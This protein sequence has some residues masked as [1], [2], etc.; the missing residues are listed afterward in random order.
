MIVDG[1]RKRIKID[2]LEEIRSCSFVERSQELTANPCCLKKDCET[3]I[4]SRRVLPGICA[5]CKIFSRL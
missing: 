1:R 5:T 2:A 3:Q 4:I